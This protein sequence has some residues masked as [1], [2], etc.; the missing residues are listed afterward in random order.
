MVAACGG[1]Q[2][3]ANSVCHPVSQGQE[4]G[5]CSMMRLAEV[6]IRAGIWMSL[7]RIVPLRTLLR[8]VPVRE[9]T[10]RER[11]K[12][13]VASTSQ[14]AFALNTPEGRWASALSFRSA[15]TCSMMACPRRLLSAVTVSRVLILKKAEAVSVEE[16]ALS[17]AFERVQFRDPANGPAPGDAF[18]D[19]P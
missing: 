6:E 7:R 3:A 18:A 1:P 16:G 8:S 4:V 13:I 14:A 10:A 5:R 15:L 12:A 19:L 2:A 11:L 9:P 17:V